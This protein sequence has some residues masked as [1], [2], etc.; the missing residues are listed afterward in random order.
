MGDKKLITICQTGGEFMTNKDG[1]LSYN[2]GDAHA[3]DIDNETRFEDYL[4]E[5]AGMWNYSPETMTMKYILPGHGKTLITVSND[6]DLKR[7]IS[8]HEN[9]TTADV[10]VITRDVIHHDVSNMPASRSSRTTISEAVVPIDDTPVDGIIINSAEPDPVFEAPLQSISPNQPPAIA[11]T[12][13]SAAKHHR[14]VE[15]EN[16][17]TGVDQRFTNV[18]EFREALRKYSIAHGFAYKF[19]KNDSHRVT[20]KCKSEGCPWRLHA[21]RLSTTQLFC[22][23]K[24]SGVH[25]CDGSTLTSGYQATTNWVAGIVKEK[26]RESSN[27]KPKDIV[28]DI[29][30]DF[31]I[32]LNYSQ[33][34][35]AKEI[36]R[37]QLQGSYKEAYNQ[38]PYFCEKIKETNPGSHATYST[39]EDSSFH[40]LFVAFH[41]SLQ[42]FEQGCRPL[43][44]LDSTPLNSKYQGTLLS[45][46]AADGDDGVF[47]VAF[48]IVDA[49]TDDNWR[50]FLLEL[51]SSVTTSQITFV[52][53]MQKGLSE[54]IPE[55]FGDAKHSYCL[56]Y[57]TESFKRDL[58]TQ[59]SNEVKRLLVAD[60]HSAAYATRYEEFQRS[61]ESI[62]G[63]SPEA[64]NW[65]HHNKPEQ[66]ATV[67][68]QG[69]RYNHMTANFGEMFYQWVSEAHELPITQMVDVIRRKMMELIYT[70]RVDSNQWSSSDRLT[71]SAEQKLRNDILKAQSFR[72]DYDH[73][74]PPDNNKFEVR[75]DTYSEKVDIG[76]KCDC[77]C[78]AWKLSGL[79]CS[80]A[81][82]CMLYTGK[83]VYAYC[84]RYFTTESYRLTYSQSINPVPNEDTPTKID[85]S[86]GA[87]LITP[88][89]ARR[90]PGRPKQRVQD[91]D[92]RKLQCSNCKGFGH[93]KSTCKSV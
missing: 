61:H 57:L 38:L 92:K 90:T 62:K 34:W 55:V 59:F 14:A 37:D 88:P 22:I 40:R 18:H 15:W 91:L 28:T 46:T 76:Q 81:I 77:S 67:F 27:Y 24:V 54:S 68:F 85:S 56:R 50:W 58:K 23:K 47:P 9:S 74:F 84:S 89:P 51:R 41:A 83:D 60:L 10:F 42:G 87:V 8:F 35:R 80:H 6:K 20:V 48:A 7:M 21:S 71:P 3:I 4:L 86:E 13:A 69:A 63:I 93:N 75:G 26:L 36:A 66:W 29:K 72:V 45:A 64:Y 1:S 52:A 33:A 70:R 44:F 17:I 79:P 31:G 12:A 5:L 25:T 19:I 32:E 11:M 78:R 16:T 65:V 49:E 43:L 30:R 2:G 39:K 82:A 73:I 53:D